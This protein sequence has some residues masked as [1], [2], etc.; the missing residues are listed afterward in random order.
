MPLVILIFEGSTLN[1]L[2]QAHIERVLRD[3]FLFRKL[4]DSQCQVLLD[5]M[6]RFEANP[7]DIV[8][9]Q[10]EA[11]SSL[12]QILQQIFINKHLIS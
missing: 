4:T 8:V 11:Y 6:Q 5:C 3:H 7:G 9:K 2:L 10:V 1:F 12:S